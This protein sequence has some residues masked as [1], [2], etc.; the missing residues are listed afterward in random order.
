MILGS[1]RIFALRRNAE[2]SG[3]GYQKPEK[4]RIG[5]IFFKYYT[6]KGRRKRN[7]TVQQAAD[8]AEQKILRHNTR[9]TGKIREILDNY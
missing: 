5:I 8:T 7:I 9:Y 2:D 3:K 1:C 4:L 6:G